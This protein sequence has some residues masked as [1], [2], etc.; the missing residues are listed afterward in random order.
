MKLS[1]RA[2]AMLKMASSADK[3]AIKKAS[4]LLLRY[5]IITAKRASTIERT[6]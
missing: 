5:D 1:K 6:L 3:S 4:S 2:K